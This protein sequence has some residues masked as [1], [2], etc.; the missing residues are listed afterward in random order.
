MGKTGKGPE[1]EEV[2]VASE[3]LF[4]QPFCEG[5]EGTIKVWS[6]LFCEPNP[7]AHRVLLIILIDAPGGI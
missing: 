6:V 3:E 5:I 1:D 7:T 2:G 4:Y